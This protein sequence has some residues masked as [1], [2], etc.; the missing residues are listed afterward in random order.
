M[1]YTQYFTKNVAM[2][3]AKMV[4]KYIDCKQSLSIYDYHLYTQ[5]QI[6]QIYS[7]S[8]SFPFCHDIIVCAT[9]IASRTARIFLYELQQTYSLLVLIMIINI[10]LARRLDRLN[11]MRTAM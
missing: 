9:V 1:N 10:P 8:F 2:S 4:Q 7:L 11:L 3:V 6:P 5:K